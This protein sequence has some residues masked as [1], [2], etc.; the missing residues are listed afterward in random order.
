M[1]SRSKLCRACQKSAHEVDQMIPLFFK[2]RIFN[3]FATVAD[4]FTKYTHLK[5]EP[6]EQIKPSLCIACY[7]VLAN[8]HK[9]RKMC[10]ASHFDFLKRKYAI[11]DCSVPLT[12]IVPVKLE[13]PLDIIDV[14][15]FCMEFCEATMKTNEPTDNYKNNEPC[16]SF[17]GS[18]SKANSV[19]NFQRIQFTCEFC[20]GEFCTQFKLTDHRK[21]I[22][23]ISKK[24]TNFHC[25]ICRKDFR[26]LDQMGKHVAVKHAGK[27]FCCRHQLNTKVIYNI[28]LC[29][30]STRYWRHKLNHREAMHI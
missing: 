17:S 12:P 26:N 13:K 18:N 24:S 15:E 7:E 25:L 10:V 3:E 27:S 1:D 16:S 30:Y 6:D 28:F 22:H 19:D 9:F 14:Q 21:R 23:H 20:S 29:T 4:L 5:I 11:V 8:F 2:N